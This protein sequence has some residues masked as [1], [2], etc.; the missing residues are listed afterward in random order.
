MSGCR[1]RKRR[2]TSVS[3]TRSSF[4]S[5]SRASS[6]DASEVAAA[7]AASS[8][9]NGSPATAAPSSTLR[10]PSER[11]PSSSA[12]AAATAGGTSRSPGESGGAPALRSR[13]QRSGELL[14]I[15]GV[16]AGVFVEGV[17]ASSSTASPRSSRAS[18]RREGA[19]L[20]ASQRPR[21]MRALE[22]GGD[23]LR[24]LTRADRERHEH[25][26]GRRPAQQAAKQLDRRRVRPVEIVEE[27]HQWRGRRQPLE[28]LA[29][30]PVT[31]VALVL[32]RRPGR[33]PE[34][35]ECGQN[36][37]QLGSDVVVERIEAARL[38]PRHVLVER[39]DEHPERQ[40]SLE[41]R[42]RPVED[43]RPTRVSTSRELTEEA[44]LADARLAHQRE[45]GRPPGFGLGESGVEHAARLGAPDELLATRDHFRSGR[46]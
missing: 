8:G 44:R 10:A 27:E 37:R 20:E 33:R 14:E 42:G 32:E 15:E 5:S 38:E 36:D 45:R 46:A 28:E 43:E 40:V 12:S 26:S 9:W 23:A 31:A 21:A 11:S 13:A 16:A 34:P 19:D 22:R 3:R 24:R 1:K 25:G 7:A 6:A 18:P 4:S 41:L 29:N 2:G 39:I 30:R 17:R 35:G